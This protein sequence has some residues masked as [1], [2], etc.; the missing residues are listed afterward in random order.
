M[1][2][3]GLQNSRSCSR[4]SSFIKWCSLRGPA[5]PPPG[6]ILI[7]HPCAV[8]RP[9]CRRWRQGPRQQPRP[10]FLKDL[11]KC[12]WPEESNLF[13]KN[14]RAAPAFETLTES[15]QQARHVFSLFVRPR[16][17]TFL[18]GAGSGDFGH[19]LGA[20]LTS[21]DARHLAVAVSSQGGTQ[22]CR[23]GCQGRCCCGYRPAGFW[24]H[25]C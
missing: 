11:I 7:P 15:Y 25:R 14:K 19:D 13:S 22:G 21:I 3:S 1:L 12:W 20:G 17:N 2:T 5:A 10:C 9:P 8:A 23:C 18:G 24:R 4:W 6:R 16:Y